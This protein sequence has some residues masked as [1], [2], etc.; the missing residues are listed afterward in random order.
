MA[1]E[2]GLGKPEK[3]RQHVGGGVGVEILGPFEDRLDAI[4]LPRRSFLV[5]LVNYVRARREF[6]VVRASL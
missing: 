1:G 3:Q 5:W 4:G 2:L 6:G